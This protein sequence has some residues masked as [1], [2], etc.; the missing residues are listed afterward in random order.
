MKRF[1]VCFFLSVLFC[2][3]IFAEEVFLPNLH[4]FTLD[5]NF[6]LFINEEKN[7][8]MPHVQYVC[9]AGYSHQG[10]S[11]AGFFELYSK[12]FLC[13]ADKS[14]TQKIPVASSISSDIVSYSCDITPDKLGQ[15]IRQFYQCAASASFADADI[16][17]QYREMKKQISDYQKSAAGFLNSAIESRMFPEEPWKQNFG[18]NLNTFSSYNLEQ[19]KTILDGIRFAY[20]TP[21]NSI[22]IITGNVDAQKIAGL[23][24]D[25]F[26][27]WKGTFSGNVQK[28]STLSSRPQKK[29]VLS[30]AVFS[31][32]I[33]QIAVQ[34]T[35]FS[36]SEAESASRIF[37]VSDS[38]FKNLITQEKALGVRGASYLSAAAS[39]ESMSARLILQGMMEEPYAFRN[40]SDVVTPEQIK[41]ANPAVQSEGFV[42]K[43]KEALAFSKKQFDSA[44]EKVAASLIMG[45]S[46]GGK[47]AG[48]IAG[49]WAERPSVTADV[50]YAAFLEHYNGIKGMS[51]A[52]FEKKAAQE[53][54]FVFVMVNDSIYNEYEDAFKN[55]GYELITQQN[56]A[57]YSLPE[58][59]R[60]EKKETDESPSKESAFDA[61]VYANFFIENIRTISSSSLANGIP[62][63]VKSNPGSKTVVTSISIA[64]GEAESSEENLYVRTLLIKAF[65]N[66]IQSQM[67]SLRDGGYLA[68]DVRINAWTTE[69]VSYITMECLATELQTA[70]TALVNAVV[71]GEVTPLLAD[72][73]INEQNYQIRLRTASLSYQLKCTAMQYM[74]KDSIYERL[75]DISKMAEL[76]PTDY[77][78]IN[79]SYTQLLDASLYSLVICGDVS[80]QDAKNAA[81]KTL[82][83]LQV[84]QKRSE[85]AVPLPE[86][87]TA[88]LNADVKHTYMSDKD[89]EKAPASSPLLIPTKKFY[90]PM[91]FYFMAPEYGTQREIFN[92]LLLELEK[93]TEED[94]G[95]GYECRTEKATSIV[96]VGMIEAQKLLHRKSFVK[97]FAAARKK[98][99][100]ALKNENTS[101]ETIEQIRDLW[102]RSTMLQTQ[103]N[104]GIARLI[105]NGVI[106]KNANLYLYSYLV[107]Q[108]AT[109]DD[110]LNILE[111]Y[112]SEDV[113][114]KVFSVDSKE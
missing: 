6:M 110:F 30:S 103:T 71:Y 107:I 60:S 82:G 109:S 35:G 59:T 86:F 26:G 23:V 96:N 37:N 94:L 49:F 3:S 32:D 38:P 69:V 106:D 48:E 1:A 16:D 42:K 76:N 47:L 105:Q 85:M 8:A 79:L 102:N 101:A 73:L 77:Q 78:A 12:L 62:L 74:F 70:L 34:Y 45:T 18:I 22:L 108:N 99:C 95:D 4:I 25:Y 83:I 21:D 50:F 13:S 2:L 29:F 43:T 24:A 14:F 72:A 93:L 90:D 58:Y 80:L 11:D 46:G 81:E 97:S 100:A 88:V 51:L 19:V 52:D 39:N 20:Y 75:Y 36:Q 61:G 54:P 68:G 104:D 10:M 64:G 57:W 92:A 66:C 111:K 91:Q 31:K 9:R 15:C 28:K 67:T 55:F 113:I 5:N 84:Q 27:T 44:K 17:R 7:S 56:A 112:I 63:V 65:A 89:A 40:E 87:K 53:T 114:L 41:E 98:L 33:T